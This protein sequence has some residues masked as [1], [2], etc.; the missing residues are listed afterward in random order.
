MS[1]IVADEDP[2]IHIEQ[3]FA[4]SALESLPGP[5]AVWPVWRDNLQRH[6]P[7]FKASFLKPVPGSTVKFF[8]CI[9]GCPCFHEVVRQSDGR[10]LGVCHCG[11][12]APFIVRPNDVIPL[13]PD[14]P[15]LGRSLCAALRLEL[16]LAR[17]RHC[18]T[19]QIGAFRTQP[20]LLTVQSS[21]AEFVQVLTALQAQLDQAFILLSPTTRL[22]SAA[23]RDRLES[24]GAACFGL[25]NLLD[26][27]TDGSLTLLRNP[28][29]LFGRLPVLNHPS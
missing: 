18:N 17:P 5:I 23:G 9:H 6:Y 4:W 13:A 26:F 22:L 24:V 28:V 8:P 14:W 21:A 2:S 11:A 25:E 19:F 16:K 1:I 3:S 15:K 20:V 12:C 29:E 27:G 10:M 7:A